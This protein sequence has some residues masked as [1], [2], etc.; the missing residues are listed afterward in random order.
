MH[1]SKSVFA[2]FAAEIINIIVMDFQ[3]EEETSVVSE[4]TLA[5]GN[6]NVQMPL[7][8]VET[9]EQQWQRS[10]TIDEFRECCKRRLRAM[11]D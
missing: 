10:L 9:F 3:H 1:F 11:Y 5:Y 6:A 8:E 7:Q 2:I 4:P